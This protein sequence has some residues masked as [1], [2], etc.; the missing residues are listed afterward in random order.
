LRFQKNKKH[1]KWKGC[2]NISGSYFYSLQRGAK[3]RGLDFTITIEYLWDLFQKQNG[4]CV[5]SGE[6]LFF[7]DARKS[8]NGTASLDRKDPKK[9]YCQE[10]LQ[11][12]SQDINYMKQQMNNEDFLNL[13]KKIYKFNYE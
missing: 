7:S 3:T 4:R 9:G 11:W 8:H 10:N 5:F 12:V 13:I 2:G 1:P 6:N